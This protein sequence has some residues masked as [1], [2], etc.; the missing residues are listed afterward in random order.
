MDK[1]PKVTVLLSAYNGIKFLKE[2]LDSLRFQQN[3]NLSVLIR[4]DGS[5]DNGSTNKLISDYIKTYPD[6][7]LNFYSGP[8]LGWAMS[9]MQL[10]YDAPDSDYYAFCDQD[11]I[12][13]P[14]KLEEALK[15][16]DVENKQCP[17]LY[18][19]NSIHFIDGKDTLITNN[20]V[21]LLNDKY[22][23]LMRGL[24][25][26]CTCVFNKS[27]LE[28][29]KM[30][31]GQK[32]LAHDFHTFVTAVFLGKVIFDD[33]AYIKYRIHGGN[34]LGMKDSTLALWKRRFKN[35]TKNGAN[36]YRQIEAKCLIN[37]YGEI[38]DGN[39][40]S[41]IQGVANYKTNLRTWSKLL[42]SK[43][44]VMDYHTNTIFAKLRI[45]FRI[46]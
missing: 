16:L 20:N 22:R 15:L 9:F 36:N 32:V 24:G 7:D 1:H 5:T 3:V 13:L 30:T 31:K 8:N 33:R 21:P 23:A 29:L 4:N 46:F 35:L 18:C 34:Q 44:Y 40:L 26:G 6:F 41:I 12:W 38:L 27:L 37:S 14:N 43:K 45:L 19:S 25:L 17:L 10:I 42:F 2:Q 11:D 28:I 39:N